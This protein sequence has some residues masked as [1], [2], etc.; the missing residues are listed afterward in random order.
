MTQ[1]SYEAR[2]P[3]A[4]AEICINLYPEPNPRNAPFPT[5]HYPA[6][7]LSLSA[8]YSP[9]LSGA[10]RGLYGASDGFLYA[11]IGTSIINVRPDLD[12]PYSG[13]ITAP[14]NSGNPVVFTD[15]GT[16]LVVVD[17]TNWGA[18]G[19]LLNISGGGSIPWAQIT[20][21]A[22]Y[23]ANRCDFIDT[24]TIFNQ[25][26][27]Q[28]FYT[29]TSNII[30]PFDPTYWA[31]KA[32]WNDRL[33]SLAA[34]HDNIWLL[35]AATTEVWFN[36][37]GATFPFAR[38]P[39]SI[40]QQGCIAPYSVVVADNAVYWLSQDRWGNSFMM[41]GEGYAA[42]RVSNFAVEY[43]W[44]NYPIVDDCI[45]MAF[46]FYGH[47]M[48]GFLFP[49]GNAYWV[50]DAS[51]EFWHQRTYSNGQAWLPMCTAHVTPAF[52]GVGGTYGT[53]AGSRLGPQIYN[54]DP[55]AY[56]DNGVPIVRQRS[57]S[58]HQTEGT[59]A[60][61]PHFALNMQGSHL[62]DDNI[63]LDWSDDLGET[64]GNGVAQTINNKANGQYQW[65]RL[66]YTRDRVYR[67]TFSGQGAFGLNGA[68]LDVIPMGT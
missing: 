61:H 14:T 41:R 29:T 2:G 16:Q 43:A 66:G 20:D 55:Y 24:F 23:G 51:T 26:T 34:L 7:G 46:Q 54:I 30:T 10:V 21:P 47:E 17:G 9:W 1:G 37:G 6:P 67:I 39:N 25:P 62:A 12:P 35:G 33:I 63:T 53:V 3:L 56:T 48:V 57:W 13:L 45:G 32:G 11:C 64:Y 49:S 58:H 50:Y 18:T 36:A 15:N 40:I 27:T 28:N 4:S 42:R 52:F 22:F 31:S 5:T 60:H 65:R 38:M 68:Y 59:R 19:G 8:D 44:Q